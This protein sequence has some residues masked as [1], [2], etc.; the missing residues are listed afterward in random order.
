MRPIATD[1]LA[2]SDGRYVYLFVTTMSPAKTA[3]PIE[4]P[5]EMWIWVRPKN[6]ML[7]GGPDPHTYIGN[8]EGENGPARTCP[9]M[10]DGRYTQSDAA[11]GNTRTGAA[12]YA[13]DANWGVLMG[14]TLTPRDEYDRTVRVRRRCGLTS[15]YFATCSF[16]ATVCKT[17]RPVLSGHC[18]VL[19]VTLVYCAMQVG[20]GPG[21]IVLYGDPAPHTERSTA[22]P[23]LKFTWPI[24]GPCLFWPNGWMDQDA[25]W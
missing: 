13:A 4:T 25:S 24:R 12:P 23:L 6:H 5:F 19:S 20:L 22:A 7:D 16:W 2:W 14:C 10:P 17:V 18:P 8:F 1:G 21:H 15:N 11:R 3:E 9:D